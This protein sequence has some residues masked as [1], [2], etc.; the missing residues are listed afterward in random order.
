MEKLFSLELI[1]QFSWSGRSSLTQEIDKLVFSDK[2]GFKS[3]IFNIVNYR[4]QDEADVR[5]VEKGIKDFLKRGQSVLRRSRK[6]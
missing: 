5:A 2:N 1:V 4:Q 6:T 3:L